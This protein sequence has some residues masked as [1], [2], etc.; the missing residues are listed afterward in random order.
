MAS[1]LQGAVKVTAEIDIERI[2]SLHWS[3]VDKL[4]LHKT[5]AIELWKLGLS[6]RPTHGCPVFRAKEAWPPFA[7]LPVLGISDHNMMGVALVAA[8]AQ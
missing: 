1:R 5:I 2:N 3:P 7:I 4:T 8:G 6:H